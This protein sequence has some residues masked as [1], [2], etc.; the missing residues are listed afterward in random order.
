MDSNSK[1]SSDKSLKRSHIVGQ[2]I[3][4][5][6]TI[7]FIS[8]AVYV[9]IDPDP[10]GS[11]VVYEGTVQEI[12]PTEISTG[13]R[14]GGTRTVLYLKMNGL[15]EVLGIHEP[16]TKDLDKFT[17]QIQPGD[18]IKVHFWS[19]G[20]RRNNINFSLYKIEKHGKMIKEPF[21]GNGDNT[22]IIVLLFGMA[23]ACLLLSMY[24]YLDYKK[25]FKAQS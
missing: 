12:G 2:I 1:K 21:E 3:M 20:E 17:T 22:F 23:G 19:S 11:I 5:L 7:G 24:L 10:P 13:S 14:F 16:D 9:I 4:M 25:K 8:A 18:V 6:A 15:D